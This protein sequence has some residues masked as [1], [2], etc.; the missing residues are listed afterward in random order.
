MWALN[1]STTSLLSSRN[2]MG[3]NTT[4]P[5]INLQAWTLNGTT[6][7]A[8]AASVCQTIYLRCLSNSSIHNPPNH[9]YLHISVFPSPTVLSCTSHLILTLQYSL[10]LAANA[11]SKKLWGHFCTTQGLLITNYSLLS[12]P[13]P[14]TKPRLQS[15]QNKR[16]TSSSTMSLLPIQMML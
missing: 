7:P 13:L 3:Y 4:W 16:F 15:P 10:M 1:T 6:L 9:G 14:P 5:A 8:A 11:T 2:S 12:V